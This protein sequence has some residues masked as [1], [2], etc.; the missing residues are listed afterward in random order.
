[1]GAHPLPQEISN[2]WSHNHQPRILPPNHCCIHPTRANYICENW[3]YFLED[4]YKVPLPKI[5]TF[6]S[7]WTQVNILAPYTSPLTHF[8]K[9]KNQLVKKVVSGWISWRLLKWG[10][11]E[12]L[13][14]NIQWR[15]VLKIT[16][17][18]HRIQYFIGTLLSKSKIECYFPSEW[19]LTKIVPKKWSFPV[20]ECSLAHYRKQFE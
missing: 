16:T 18:N 19:V 17:E 12:Y 7:Y 10:S 9:E 20:R 13:N 11:A 5:Y 1:M 2:Y 8:S 3:N 14:C 15:W 6:R 4:Q